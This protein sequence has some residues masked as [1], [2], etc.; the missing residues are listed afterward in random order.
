M[1]DQLVVP[2]EPID[3]EPATL[4]RLY[5]LINDDTAW[6]NQAAVTLSLGSDDCVD[7]K[8]S[9]SSDLAGASWEPCAPT[10]AFTLTGADGVKAVYA[11][12]RD[13]LG[14]PGVIVS[15]EILLDRTA[16]ITS[17]THDAGSTPKKKNDVIHFTL[18]A[19][20]EPGGTAYVDVVG[21]QS[22]ILLHDDG[23]HGDAVAGN[24]VYETDYVVPAQG[25]VNSA[26]VRG[27]FEDS[28]SNTAV[29]VN[30][31]TALTIANPPV[32]FNVRIVPDTTHGTAAVS[33]D[34]DEPTTG[35]IQWGTTALY[36]TTVSVPAPVAMTHTVSIGGGALVPSQEYH[37][38]ITATDA[39]T[40]SAYTSDRIFYLKPSPPT[41][42][43]AMPGDGR[44]DVRWEAP[45]QDN[46]VGYN[47]YRS[48]ISG[49]LYATL[50][51]TGLY[52]HE[53]LM[54]SDLAVVNDATYFYVITAVDEFGHESDRSEEVGGMP[55]ANSGPT[56]VGGALVGNQVWTTCRRPRGRPH[57]GPRPLVVI[58]QGRPPRHGRLDH[59]QHPVHGHAPD[60]ADRDRLPGAGGQDLRG[61]RDR[62]LIAQAGSQ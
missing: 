24:G 53:A 36:G 52:N 33:W 62:A 38:R 58:E 27:R 59:H 13:S 30:A 19:G 57:H 56:Y 35:Q 7:L 37:V 29:N 46:V 60:L 26:V 43:I 9:Q 10:R 28:H 16:V 42:V 3:L 15:D 25:D 54:Y 18:N 39:A 21:F 31:S 14:I 4:R 12:F 6:T 20:G 61:A 44:F 55:E 34:T 40:N 17:V 49:G 51:A 5:V 50:N 45:P 41:M 23:T 2:G 1:R 48:S 8:V 32:I 47:V 11:Q 22:G